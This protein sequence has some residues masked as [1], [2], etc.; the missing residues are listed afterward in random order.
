M[1]LLAAI[2]LT[3]FGLATSSP[4]NSE[5]ND[6]RMEL[7]SR[8]GRRVTVE[9]EPTSLLR[10][11]R[12]IDFKKALFNSLDESG[13][14][15]IT[16]SNDVSNRRSKNLS[17]RKRGRKS[18]GKGRKGKGKGRKGRKGRKGKGKKK[19]K[20]K[21]GRKNKKNGNRNGKNKNGGRRK[22]NRMPTGRKPVKV[23]QSQ[24][25][26]NLYNYAIDS[27]T[28]HDAASFAEQ[29]K[30]QQT[31]KYWMR[32]QRR[33]LIKA[34]KNKDDEESYESDMLDDYAE[35]GNMQREIR[36]STSI[37]DLFDNKYDMN[38][39]AWD[40]LT[41]RCINSKRNG[42]FGDSS[43]DGGLMGC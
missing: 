37:D 32:M 20:S 1:K 9:H 7:P 35:I 10:R 38:C 13:V 6:Y 17:K 2:T 25:M 27:P 22:K 41:G 36:A 11:S 12:D 33:D 15:T 34:S 42:C 43:D 40:P 19:R 24:F 39:L 29:K 31:R 16:S 4:I 18:K 23:E 5:N 3:I 26:N 30:D 28:D 14:D 8:S 21:K